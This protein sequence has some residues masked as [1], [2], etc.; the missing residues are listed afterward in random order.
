M[1]RSTTPSRKRNSPVPIRSADNFGPHFVMLMVLGMLLCVLCI[2][3]GQIVSPTIAEGL[4][5]MG[6]WIAVSSFLL[7]FVLE[8]ASMNT[9]PDINPWDVIAHNDREDR[10]H[11]MNVL[12]M[13]A[14][15]ISMI[16][17][18]VNLG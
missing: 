10:R 16:I 15:G 17:S 12:T 5:A 2:A 3:T 14:V 13:V 9:R 18:S 7:G 11:L 8:P 4:L 6:L 1:S